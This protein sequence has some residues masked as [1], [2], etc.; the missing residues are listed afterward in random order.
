MKPMLASPAKDITFPVYASPKIDGIRAYVQN[1]ALLSRSAKLIP[2]RYV[3]DTLG[4][5]V[6]NGVDGELCVGP[7]NHPNLMQRTTSGCMSFDG[8]PEFTYWIF[9]VWGM[10]EHPFEERLQYLNSNILANYSYLHELHKNNQ[11]QFLKQ[12]LIMNEEVLN[13]FEE[14]CLA[15]GYEGIMVRSP[16][17]KYKFGRSTAREGALLKVKRWTD[18]EARIIDLK[19]F[20]HNSNELEQDNFGYAKRSSHQAGKVPMDL[21]GSFICEDLA[22]GQPVD[23]GTGYTMEQR[24]DFWARRKEFQGKIVK[25]KHFEQAGVKDAPRFPVFLGF[26][27]PE[28]M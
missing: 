3:Q 14:K 11:I 5:H 21:L 22:T 6:L 27:H 26:R 17:A 12:M 13:A 9:D 2:N 28:D 23:I 24:R 4:K 19:Q 15:E 10:S 8:Q 1:G 20:M 25:Y 16:H 18:G 7:S